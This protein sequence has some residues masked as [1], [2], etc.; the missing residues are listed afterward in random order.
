[1]GS[2]VVLF[3]ECTYAIIKITISDMKVEGQKKMIN[4]LFRTQK[5]QG[6]GYILI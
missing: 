1:M 6:R 4:K 2:G 5:K 3:S